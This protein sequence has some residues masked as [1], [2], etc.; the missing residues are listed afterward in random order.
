MKTKIKK[1][2]LDFII[3][4]GA[5]LKEILENNN[6]LQEE[7]AEKTGITSKYINEVIKGKKEISV[8][9]A[10]S[11]EC[12][13]GIPANFWINLQKIYDKEKQNKITKH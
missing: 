4:P 5:T 10:Q 11:L 3:H 12:A 7:L 13:L 2:S 6:M 8:K 1:L 9:L